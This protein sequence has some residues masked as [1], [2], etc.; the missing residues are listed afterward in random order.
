[1]PTTPQKGQFTP[2]PPSP[3]VSAH[4]AGAPF[5]AGQGQPS[6][7]SKPDIEQSIL[8]KISQARAREGLF[9]A[10]SAGSHAAVVVAVSGG[11]DSVTLL[12]LLMRMRVAWSLDLVVAHLDHSLRPES[13]ADARFVAALAERWRL[14]LQL[15]TLTAGALAHEGNLEA[16][17]RRARYRFLA[18]VAAGLQQADRPVDVAVAHNANDQAET[19]L[20][21]LVRGSGLEGL[22]AMQPARPMS[23]DKSQ[24]PGVRVVRPLLDVTRSEILRYLEQQ[25]IPWREDPTNLD[26]RLVRNRI[27]HEILPRLQEINPQIVGSLCRTASIMAAEAKTR[28]SQTRLALRAARLDRQGEGEVEQDPPGALHAAQAARQGKPP[29]AALRQ[30]FDLAAFRAL[31]AADQ[32]ALLRAAWRCLGKPPAKLGFEAVERIRRS[33]V[34]DDRVGGPFTWVANLVYTRTTGVFSLHHPHVSPFDTLHPL[35]GNAWRARFSARKLPVPGKIVVGDWTL[36]AKLVHRGELASD[37]AMQLSPWE[38]L[39]DAAKVDHLAL[40]APQPG[41]R[42]EPLGLAGHGKALADYFT[43]RKVPRYLRRAWPLVL[44][45]TEI[46]W[47]CGCQIADSVR[48]TADS[49]RIIHLLWEE[50]T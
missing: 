39:I 27:R 47:V 31:G 12:H 48:I 37:W 41:L 36:R 34:E 2:V 49:Q 10:S 26:R 5:G 8:D 50:R 16:A 21:N 29:A 38:A 28:D 30:V 20:M 9:P 40:S 17:A 7:L 4:K 43:D 32:R 6:H 33:L 35:L 24:L 1:M 44:N 45:R 11:A 22:S 23:V 18:Q 13:A 25:D 15:A 3:N 46:A 14:P 19:V 42:F